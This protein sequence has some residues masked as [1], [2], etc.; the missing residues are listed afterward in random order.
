MGLFWQ[1]WWSARSV[2]V[3]E[4]NGYP[5]GPGADLRGANL[6]GAD[7]SGAD[8][9][10]AN[11]SGADL[12]WVN[13]QGVDLSDAEF[14]GLSAPPQTTNWHRRYGDVRRADLRGANLARATLRGANLSGGVDGCSSFVG[15]DLTAA[16]LSGTDLRNTSLLG[17]EFI[18]ADLSGANLEG[19]YI[20]GTSFNEADL[21]GANLDGLP[22]HGGE[23]LDALVGG[24][25]TRS[26]FRLAKLP[27]ASL[28]NS[29][30]G[31][32]DFRS[33]DLS[34]ASFVG[35]NLSGADFD[36][37]RYDERT[38][39][40][41]RFK[42]DYDQAFD[43]VVRSRWESL[44]AMVRADIEESRRRRR[45]NL[46]PAADALDAL[47]DVYNYQRSHIDAFVAAL[48]MMSG[49]VQVPLTVVDLGAGACTVAFAI[50]EHFGL[51]ENE[52]QY[53]PVEPNREMRDLGSL[54]LR[55]SGGRL[56]WKEPV[57]SIDELSENFRFE[58]VEDQR[59][60]LVSLS[61][62]V[63][64]PT[65]TAE[66]LSTWAS[67]ISDW[68]VYQG[69][70]V[71]VLSTTA[72]SPDSGFR[73]RDRR[74]LLKE[75]LRERGCI[76]HERIHTCRV[77]RKHPLPSGGWQVRSPGRTPDWQNVEVCFWLVNSG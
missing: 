11:L 47:S 45:G 15:A 3:V 49:R 67:F 30:L 32:A 5:I 42:V 72:N 63:H 62:V 55:E 28:K 24:V 50:A 4:V 73:S 51:R 38:V 54:L 46:G 52:L 59:N 12:R 66:D 29:H 10:G 75:A 65:V 6:S 34:G 76:V 36:D 64:Q 61:Y 9:R 14:R 57:A 8:L 16:N 69:Q 71:S 17:V 19:A 74:P 70:Q 53:W 77:D 31:D 44:S 60:I 56:S 13:L 58:H 21:S 2:V 41:S 43:S 27:N 39:W 33:A 23:F 25:E 1:G 48:N 18:K 35:A 20:Y 37:V 7:L 40:P 68:A 22:D 26:S